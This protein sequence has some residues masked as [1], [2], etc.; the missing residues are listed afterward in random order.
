MNSFFVLGLLIFE[1]GHILLYGW[2]PTFWQKGLW[3]SHFQNPSESSD[4]IRILTHAAFMVKSSDI[5]TNKSL[6]R[7]AWCHLASLIRQFDFYDVNNPIHPCFNGIR[8]PIDVF[9][10][11]ECSN[12]TYKR[13]RV[14]IQTRFKVNFNI[15][16]FNGIAAVI[17]IKLAAGWH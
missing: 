9:T 7:L 6:D 14:S 10:T 5:L 2:A 15:T 17:K 13:I 12:H 4:K 1:K 16:H 11:T 3:D 8:Q